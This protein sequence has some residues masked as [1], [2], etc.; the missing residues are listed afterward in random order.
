MPRLLPALCLVVVSIWPST[1]SA[2]QVGD[3]IR[4]DALRVFLD[5][6]TRNC[7]SEYFRTEIAFVNWVRD[8]TLA[9]VHLII[10]SAQTGGGGNVFSL[11]FVGLQDLEGSDDGLSLTA[12]GTDTDDEVL[13]GL[14]RVMAAG[15][16]RYTTLI[17]RSAAF[18]IDAAD[19]GAL[20]PDRLLSAGT[21]DDP[22][23]FWVF[24]ASVDLEME[25]EEAERQREYSGSF[26]ASRTT[27]SWKIEIESNGNFSRE[28]QDLPDGSTI[29]DERTN[30]NVGLLMAYSLADRWSTAV[31]A[32]AG[33]STRRNQDFGA[34][35]SLAI[36]FSF[37][38]YEDATRRSLT[39][40]YDV[41][42][43]YFDWIEE[44]VLFETEELRPQH[45]VQ[46]QLFQLQPWG[47]T[48]A[49]IDARQFL[50]D[51]GL[52][53]IS[54]NGDL[55][56][57]IVRGVDLEIGGD[58]AFIEDQIFISGEGLTLEEILQ[59][60]FERPTDFSYELS[61]GLSFEFGSIY[62]NVVNNRF[63]RRRGFGG[64]GF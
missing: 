41:G 2:R 6:N 32:G 53:S 15:L 21:V 5:C 43:Q 18:R 27:D 44:T 11:D 51:P 12:P 8:R 24:E 30:W 9:Q 39:A 57:R 19:A 22:W 35:A 46:L 37:L 7:D 54:L 3:A 55:E 40:R 62:N 25:G 16:A 26:D 58:V 10:T 33:A 47:E 34:D 42:L 60:R 61:V 4:E 63:D 64:G 23:N 56:F 13:R 20:P 1:A 50:H 17:G 59:G 52:W 28:E 14:T 31:L 38:P 49:S 29:S 45:Q 48:R 36:E